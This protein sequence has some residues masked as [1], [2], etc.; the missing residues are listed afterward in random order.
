M[1][2]VQIRSVRRVLEERFTGLIDMSD[3]AHLSGD[4][5]HQRF[6]SRALAALAV[7]IEHQGSDTACGQAV[8]DGEDDRGLDAIAIDRRPRP[9][10]ICLVQAKWSDKGKGGFNEADAHKMMEGVELLLDL[11]FSKFNRRFQRHAKVLDE[12]Y[13][14]KTVAPK[15]TVVLALMRTEPISR[16]VRE[17][18]ERK[19]KKLNDVEDMVDYKVLD[20][21]DFHRAVLGDAAAPKVDSTIRLEGFGQ[22][23]SPYKAFYGTMTVPEIAELYG[24]HRRGLFARN[25]RDAL[26]LT[27]VNVKIRSTLTDS[28]E[29]FW[30]FSNGITI[31]CE[32][33]KATR[34]AVPGGVGDFLV[35][36]ASVVN[37]AQT[38]NAIYKS[39][40][41]NPD[42]SRTGRVLVRLISLEDCP[43]GFGDQ[44]TTNTNTQNPIEERDF[45]SLDPVQNKLRDEFALE[46]SLAYVIKRGEKEPDAEH[47]CTL[48]E[49]AEALAAVHP[50]AEYAAVAKREQGEIWEDDTYHALFGKD[51]DAR[52]VWRCVR[53]LRAVRTSLE[54]KREELVWR[55]ASMASYGDLLVTHV[56]F[57]Q[58]D[59]RELSDQG[60]DWDA[61][62]KRVPKLV[63]EALT[64]SLQ[65][66]DLEYGPTS[67]IIAAVRNTERIRQVAR[68]AMRGMLSDEPVP[69][70]ISDY[71]AAPQAG[72]QVNAVKTLIEL[73]TIEEGAILEFRPY[74]APERR[75]M[76]EW[77]AEEPSR[78]QAVW[79]NSASNQLQWR[80]DGEWYS[81]SGLARK[82]R[83]EASGVDRAAQGPVRW[84]L[85]DAGSL[86]EL[87]ER[88]RAEA[89]LLVGVE[90]GVAP[91]GEA[92]T[93]GA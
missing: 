93:A 42:V 50:N 53:L 22:E 27:D 59:T 12:C 80:H 70:L 15:I 90:P 36:G 84:F 69:E 54:E 5:L 11:K 32:T 55:A 40:D 7:Q 26:D 62:L 68:M 25:I 81:P 44:V 34:K 64:R 83:Y 51:P 57:R 75:E 92:D 52:R 67:H 61:Q 13:D 77:L 91:D 46:L 8:F 41:E 89:D 63:D 3:V 29:H 9:A 85:P 43:P 38:V 28:P 10:R 20:L 47:G 4:N 31:L 17:L 78:S 66:I 88:A 14:G 33:I 19:I 30:Y 35:T 76:T 23:T 86:A 6:L 45:K 49:A 72:R 16:D 21:R 39:Y 1:S 56:V 18:L 24:E 37:G 73:G 48:T 65:A 79:R 87:A 74:S 58:L 60:F 2:V 71:Q 82:M